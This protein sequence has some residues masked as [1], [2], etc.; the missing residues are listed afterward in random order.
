M[1]DLVVE[2]DVVGARIGFGV[3][4]FAKTWL[5]LIV[6]AA[7]IKSSDVAF[8][9]ACIAALPFYSDRI[10]PTPLRRRILE[11]SQPRYFFSL[12]VFVVVAMPFWPP[13]RAADGPAAALPQMPPP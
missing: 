3:R 4:V 8:D 2:A 12:R 10:N 11:R 13:A 6:N 1:F 5:L 7:E 9:I